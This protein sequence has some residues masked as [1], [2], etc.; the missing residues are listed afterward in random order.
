MHRAAPTIVVSYR[1]KLPLD[2]TIAKEKLTEYLL[3]K[4]PENDKSGFLM[5]AGYNLDAW[6]RLEA[7]IRHQLLPLDAEFVETTEYG[8][9]YRIRGSLTGPNGRELHVV[10]IW[11]R[12]EAT[13]LTKY[14]TL[15]PAKDA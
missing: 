12:E 8:D 15:Y 11:M 2:A 13:G 14:V 6:E 5:V 10:S 1:M 3:R 7:D 9:K 4:L